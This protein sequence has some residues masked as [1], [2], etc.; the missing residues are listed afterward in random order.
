[1]SKPVILKIVK[2]VQ[3]SKVLSIE[4]IFKLSFDIIVTFIKDDIFLNIL[5]ITSSSYNKKITLLIPSFSNLYSSLKSLNLSP[6]I[7]KSNFEGFSNSLLNNSI[8]SDLLF[9]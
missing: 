6:F 9:T 8:V 7:I 5:S 3:F 2:L 4:L 1:M